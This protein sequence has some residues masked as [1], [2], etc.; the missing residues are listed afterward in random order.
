MKQMQKILSELGLSPSEIEVYLASLNLGEASVQEV[1]HLAKLPRTTAGSILERLN[2][3]GLVSAQTR[4]AKRIYWVEN[5]KVLA[6]NYETKV[7]LA[8]QLA[9]KMQNDYRKSDK[10]P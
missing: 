7:A 9:L 8:N 3:I 1:A 10:K 6:K 2:Q 4:A 5:P